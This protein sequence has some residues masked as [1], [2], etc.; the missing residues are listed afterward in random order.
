MNKYSDKD[1]YIILKQYEMLDALFKSLVS[2]YSTNKEL[3][4][5]TVDKLDASEL[6][7]ENYLEDTK[8]AFDKILL[9]H[10]GLPNIEKK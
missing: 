7:Y 10:E 4:E 8:K 5:K 6:P 2:L 9:I 1:I 3:W